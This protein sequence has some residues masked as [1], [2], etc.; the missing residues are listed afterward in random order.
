MSEGQPL[1]T[2]KSF[3][4]GWCAAVLTLGIAVSLCAY[5]KS[6]PMHQLSTYIGS[7]IGVLCGVH[8]HCV[9][10]LSYNLWTSVLSFLERSP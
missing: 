4:L 1:W 6:H 8:A 2:R 3:A 5:V 9:F 7:T 10:I